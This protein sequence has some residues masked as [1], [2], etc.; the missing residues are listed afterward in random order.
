MTKEI[1]GALYFSK[2]APHIIGHLRIGN[3]H[4]ELVGVRRSEIRVDLTGR[5][6]PSSQQ[7]ELDE[8]ST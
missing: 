5:R 2:N 4:F 1:V 3:I 6:L 8:N 7:G